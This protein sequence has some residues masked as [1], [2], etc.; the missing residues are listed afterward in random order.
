[1][2]ETHYPV[3][4]D[5]RDKHA[6]A[7]RLIARPGPFWNAEARVQMVHEARAALACD[8]CRR[9]KDAL[10]P[11]VVQGTHDAASA[12]PAAVI[13]MIHRVRTD[14]A[15]MTRSVFDGVLDAGIPAESYLEAVSVVC[16]SVIVDTFHNA[17]GLAAPATLPPEPGEPTGQEPPQ[18]EDAGAWVPLTTAE[19]EDGTFGLPRAPNIGRA[20]GLVPGAVA[21]FFLSFRSHYALRDIPLDISQAQAEFIAS[22]V[23]ALNECFY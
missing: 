10:S 12:L 19:V 17:L 20:M 14:P 22:R 5:L 7:W 2:Y 4:A 9:R 16:T 1:M 18:V 21:L 11:N 13:D 8:L 23:S 15:R 3:R 6:E